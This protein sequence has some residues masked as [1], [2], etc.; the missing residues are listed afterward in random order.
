MHIT[1]QASC[2]RGSA[3]KGTA[4]SLDGDDQIYGNSGSRMGRFSAC[5]PN[6]QASLGVHPHSV[7]W[8]LNGLW[9]V[10]QITTLLNVP[11]AFV[12]DLKSKNH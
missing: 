12:L 8:L 10:S 4:R 3:N 1:L 9:A 7:S 6:R 11:D 5:F 2:H